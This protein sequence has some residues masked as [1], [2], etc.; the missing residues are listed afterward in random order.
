MFKNYYKIVLRNL[1]RYKGYTLLNIIGMGIG[2]AAIAWGYQTLRFSFSYDNFHKDKDIVY[3]ALSYK[4]GGDG[5]KG[6]FPMAAVKQ[7]QND[8]SGDHRIRP[9]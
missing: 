4:A 6:I 7:A 2:I 8:F 3:R 1:W 9:L 5:V